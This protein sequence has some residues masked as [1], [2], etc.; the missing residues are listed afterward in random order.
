MH[1]ATRALVPAIYAQIAAH[2]S[3]V[4][5]LLV[6]PP[7]AGCKP[8]LH[9]PSVQRSPVE[10]MVDAASVL[11]S[12]NGGILEIVPAHGVTA[13]ALNIEQCSDGS[14]LI[15]DENGYPGAGSLPELRGELHAIHITLGSAEENTVALDV[16]PDSTIAKHLRIFSATGEDITAAC[17]ALVLKQERSA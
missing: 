16:R 17:A 12:L 10:I 7:K 13:L 9:M 8:L 1:Y 5:A 11:V 14:I 15:S 6:C 3:H 4:E 2:I